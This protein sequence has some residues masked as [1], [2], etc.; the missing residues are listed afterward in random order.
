MVK[1]ARELVIMVMMVTDDEYQETET[2]DEVS[3][4]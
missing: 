2:Y 3:L 4:S 1:K